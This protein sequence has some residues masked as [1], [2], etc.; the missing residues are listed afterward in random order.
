MNNDTP[1]TSNAY[2]RL[3][4]CL[5]TII[6]LLSVASHLIERR[7]TVVNSRLMH[8]RGWYSYWMGFHNNF[9]IT[10]LMIPHYF[11]ENPNASLVFISS[12]E[13]IDDTLSNVVFAFPSNRTIIQ[14]YE[15]NFFLTNRDELEVYLDRAVAHGFSRDGF[16]DLWERNRNRMDEIDLNDFSLSYPITMHDMVYN[17]ENV[18]NLFGEMLFLID[19]DFGT[20]AMHIHIWLIDKE[21]EAMNAEIERLGFTDLDLDFDFPIIREGRSRNAAAIRAFYHSYLEGIVHAPL[22]FENL[23]WWDEFR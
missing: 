4:A 20:R 8:A 22:F 21:L 23:A 5:I 15:M 10:P 12:R 6:V 2:Y 14:L 13:D 9:G 1:S 7:Q 18:S 3:V 17:W 11:T 16:L 19:A